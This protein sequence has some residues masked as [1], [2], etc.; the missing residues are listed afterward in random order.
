MKIKS[1]T[2]VTANDADKIRTV[3]VTL[4]LSLVNSPI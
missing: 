1:N 4:Y 2:V 3:L